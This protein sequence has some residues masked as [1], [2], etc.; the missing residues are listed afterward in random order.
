MIELSIKNLFFEGG[1]TMSKD[2]FIQILQHALDK[3]LVT[4]RK[5]KG[6]YK[7]SEKKDNK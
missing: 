1:V 7:V 6:K 2:S 5:V 3:D 4:V